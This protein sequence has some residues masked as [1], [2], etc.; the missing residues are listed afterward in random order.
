[1]QKHIIKYLSSIGKKGGLK[2]RRSL[3]SSTAKKMVKVRE[4]KK[5]F[6]KYYHQC[7]WSF[8]PHYKI[9]FEDVTWV[10][11]QLMKNGDR[12]LWKLGVKLCH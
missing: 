11:E 12:E 3:S 8:D 6:N 2:S 7:F 4:A 1:M 5:L 10:A 9:K